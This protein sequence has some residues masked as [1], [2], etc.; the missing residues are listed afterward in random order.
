MK[1]RDKRVQ[2]RK[3]GEIPCKISAFT[4]VSFRS[5]SKNKLRRRKKPIPNDAIAKSND[6]SSKNEAVM[7]ACTECP[8]R[9]LA[10]YKESQ[11][12]SFQQFENQLDALE[13]SVKNDFQE[14]AS[15][16]QDNEVENDDDSTDDIDE[17]YCVACN[18]SFK[19]DK[20]YD[21]TDLRLRLTFSLAD[22]STMKTRE[23]TRSSSN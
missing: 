7:V 17:L 3:V 5:F 20:A 4:S 15:N 6:N 16:A 19:S 10:Q 18:K 13:N 21:R 11:W 1:K 8:S 22:F 12:M 23:N 14:S 2:L 9:E